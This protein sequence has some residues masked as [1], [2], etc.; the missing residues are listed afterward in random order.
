MQRPDYRG[1]RGSNAGDDFHELWVLRKALTLLAH[2]TDLLAITVEGLREEDEDGITS[3]SWDGVDCALYYG[4]YHDDVNQRIELV[5]LKYSAA[6]PDK[7]WTLSRL[8]RSKNKKLNNSVLG[9]LAKAFKGIKET[10]PEL[11]ANKKVTIRLV[12]N[13]TVDKSIIEAILNND[14]FI[15]PE[16]AGLYKASR[17]NK[18]EYEIFI[19]SMVFDCGSNSRFAIEEHIQAEISKLMDQDFRGTV[20]FLKQQIRRKMMPEAKGEQITREV[21]LNWLGFSDERALFP[22]PTEIKKVE[23]LISRG[24]SNEVVRALLDN[25]KYVCIHGEGGCGKTTA[26][27][28]IESL[29]PENSHILV[30][31]CYGGGRYLDSDAYRHRSPDAF[32]QISNDL[33]SQ[34]QVP[35]L[36]NKMPTLDYPKIF[37]KR[38]EIASNVI[39]SIK[40]EALLVICIDAADN[41]VIAARTQAPPERSF[42]QDFVAIGELPE[43]VRF[44]IT[45][46][47][48][49]V[50]ILNLPDRYKLIPMTGFSR[51]ETA[52]YVRKIMSDVPDEWIDDFHHLSNGN[53]RV[54]HF[55]IDYSKSKP[56]LA[57]ESLRPHGKNLDQIFSE[58]LNETK[59]KAGNKQDIKLFCSAIISL[60]RQIPLNDLVKVTGFSEAYIRDLCIDLAPG[61]RLDNDL[62][63]FSDEDFES[64]IRNE[65]DSALVSIKEKIADHFVANHETDNYAATHVI[66]ALFASNRKQDVLNIIKCGEPKAVL[67][68]V[69]RRE[70]QLQ[71]LQ[72]AMRLCREAGNSVDATM[73]L[74]VGAEALKTDVAVRQMLTENFD[75]AASFARDTTARMILRDPEEIEN[76]GPFIFH[77]LA[78]DA[79]AGDAISVR[80]NQ[81]IL[82]AWMQRRKEHKEDA[83]Q[84]DNF[85]QD[86]WKIDISDIAAETEAILRMAGCKRAVDYLMRWSPRSIQ[87]QVANILVNRLLIS[88]ETDLLKESLSANI[89]PSPWDLFLLTPIALAGEEIDISRLEVGLENL[90]RLHLI[91]PEKLQE[92]Y[93]GS[94]PAADFLEIILTACEIVISHRGNS[95]KVIPVLERF[96]N[97][98]LRRRDRLHLSNVSIIDF[99]LRAH[100]LIECLAGRTATI[101]SYWIDPPKP[102]KKVLPEKIKQMEQSDED[103]KRELRDNIGPFLEI[104]N[105]RAQAI[106]G[107]SGSVEVDDNLKNAIKRFHNEEYRLRR[108][109]EAQ[110]MALQV[111][112]S[113]TRLLMLSYIDRSNLLDCAS[114]FLGPASNPFNIGESKIYQNLSIDHSLQQQI[115]NRVSDSVKAIRHAKTSADE[116]ITALIRLSRLVLPISKSDANTLFNI[117]VDVA[118]EI[119]AEVIHEIA[120]LS[121]IADRAVGSMTFEEKRV[122][123]HNL[124]MIVSDAAIRLSNH[125]HFPWEDAIHALTTLDVCLSLAAIARW[126]DSD[127]VGRANSLP[128]FIQT[129]IAQHTISAVQAVSMAPLLD[130]Y[131]VKLVNQIIEQGISQVDTLNLK[132]LIDDLAREEVLR[133]GSGKRKQINET[134]N[135]V[136][137]NGKRSLWLQ[138]LN[139]AVEFHSDQALDQARSKDDKS[140]SDRSEDNAKQEKAMGVIDWKTC[141]FI[142]CSEI[143]D[144]LKMIITSAR[145]L[146]SYVNGSIILNN[147]R[148]FVALGDQVQHLNALVNCRSKEVEDYELTRAI[149]D[150]IVN[151]KSI[152]S[153]QEWC[154][155]KLLEVIIDLLPAFSRWI[156][157]RQ[158]QLP[159]ILSLT[160]AP[161]KEIF[162]A[163]L[164]GIERHVNVLDASTLYSLIGIAGKY[165]SQIDASKILEQYTDRLVCRID[166]NEREVWDIADVPITVKCSLA[167]YLYALMSDVDIR[168]RWRSAHSLRKLACLGDIEVLDE[169]IKLYDKKV[170]SVFR[171]PDAPF[172]WLAARLWLMIALDRIAAETPSAILK[173][174]LKLYKIACD[175]TFPHVLIR[176]FAKTAVNKLVDSRSL[177]LS[178]NEKRSLESANTST[179]YSK[180]KD[181]THKS[182]LF[183]GKHKVEVDRRFQF[184][185]MDTIPYWYEDALRGFADLSMKEFLDTAEK[186]IIDRWNIQGKVWQWNEEP[187]QSRFS[188]DYRFYSHS[189]GSN[190]ILERFDTYLEWHAM[191]CTVGELLTRKTFVHD[192]ED[193]WCSYERWLGDKGLAM[194]PVW[195]TD[196]RDLKPLENRFWYEPQNIDE[197]VDHVK[198]EDFMIEL[199]LSNGNGTIVVDSY[200]STGSSEFKLTTR[201][202]TALVSP[203]TAGALVRALQTVSDPSDYRIPPEGDS[204][205]IDK[206]PYK[207]LGWLI[208]VQHESGIDEVDPLCYGIRAIECVPSGKVITALD[209]EFIHCPPRWIGKS[210]KTTFSYCAWSEYDDYANEEHYKYDK[211]VRSTGHRL[212]IDSVSLNKFLNKVDLDL[213]V[214]VEITRRNNAYGT[215]RNNEKKTKEYIFDRI[216][217]LRKEGTIETTE[218]CVGAWTASRK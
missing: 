104:Y 97:K 78:I 103:R 127:I 155:T 55:A 94:N 156:S 214:E 51:D 22:C 14:V 132:M 121:P 16:Y 63:G 59:R 153:V 207:L 36:L 117:A 10:K 27:Q 142:T 26:L 124:T 190:P 176:N 208:D 133:F 92:I 137:N 209:L 183:M 189:H 20:D 62:I 72:I 75:L 69:L 98:E 163:I 134:L 96:S 152:P 31:D 80:E 154:D 215:S 1:A 178:R 112:L 100:T 65:A 172:Y 67:D 33:S 66:P 179:N 23:Q 115:L 202:C 102:D 91:R 218:G 30:Y 205:E 81:R 169:I 37:K 197:W 167:R 114:A 64:F 109:Y 40:K 4:N 73:I 180:L 160:N 128:T 99:T 90:V 162:Q 86:S 129:A 87:L 11:V 44:I 60:P 35:L 158:S 200:Q 174:G 139:D 116:K 119:D 83:N 47:T 58:R 13:Q 181:N 3:D 43:N 113:I 145:E 216:F 188:D 15:K 61:V 146:G 6:D 191:M 157:V 144:V 173:H 70:V 48:G 50:E 140:I 25:N 7:K 125:D 42:V 161:D 149:I 12:S 212:M 199:G 79:R 182:R 76:H 41:S 213:I 166:N 168:I 52:V 21:V 177:K 24:I 74:L 8:G 38:L 49:R 101:E 29:L 170:E 184:D 141:K 120:L 18:D 159:K 32:L 210:S 2:N 204:L 53:P 28:E 118:G 206:P 201:V 193:S 108:H 147:M 77:L 19:R 196:L 148:L 39:A 106:C 107:I 56:I 122:V 198:Q 165:C 105:Y 88:G 68:P 93:T 57:I 175:K 217:L 84:D 85:G 5:Q 17:L 130:E 143:D 136:P 203:K 135:S 54:Q 123:A 126:E 95:T 46:R 171:N 110:R 34:F 82:R 89:I 195:L 45:S 186:W 164:K 138:R 151:W 71:R 211:T 9:R 194:S 187:R 150:G 192:S 111:S 131:E 185:S